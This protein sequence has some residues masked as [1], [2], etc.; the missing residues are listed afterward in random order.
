MVAMLTLPSPSTNV[1]SFQRV[2]LR[3]RATG[4]YNYSWARNANPKK[5]VSA[6]K[7]SDYLVVSLESIPKARFIRRTLHEP[8]LI[9]IKVDPNN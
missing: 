1:S 5:Y 6:P 2:H 3:K 9:P 4:F 8:N 7:I